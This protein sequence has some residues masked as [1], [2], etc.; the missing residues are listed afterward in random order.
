MR[1][2]R[3]VFSGNKFAYLWF[4][5]IL[6]QV[7]VHILNFVLLIRLFTLTGST[8]ATSLLWV[9]YALPA[10]IFG[11]FAA[12]TV[13]MVD[14]RKILL[15]ANFFQ[16]LTIFAY[17]LSHAT[18]VYL[19]YGVALVYSLFNQFYIPAEQAA[20]PTLVSKKNLAHANGLFFFTQ[21]ASIIVGFGFAGV[22]LQTLG[23]QTTLFLAAFLLGLA[24]VSV[25][26]LPTMKSVYKP[27][28]IEEVFMGFF[29][30]IFSGFDF[31]KSHRKIFVPFILLIAFQVG[32]AVVTVNIPALATDIFKI[33]A[34]NAGVLVVVPAG[35]GAA[36]GAVSVPRLLKRG[37][38]KKRIIEYSLVGL[39]AS[40]TAIA[41]FVFALAK[42][43]G[44]VLGVIAI[45]VTGL[46]F[47]GVLI[48]SQTFLQE[49]TPGGMR[50][51]VFGNFWFIVTVATVIPILFSGTITELFGVKTLFA[52]LGLSALVMLLL[53]KKIGHKV[54]VKSREN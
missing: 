18:T 33:N 19:L 44:L 39:V 6:S 36:M 14:K 40:L 10:L 11:P 22:L 15:I 2:F 25:N 5:Q 9:S 34:A 51:R 53:S 37:F 26:F 20:L 4:S 35:I 3:A 42:P 50:G 29:S 47:V 32:L 49:V 30:K 52:L 13:D 54:L 7:T 31:I 17:A 27:R 48:P 38:R 8:I 46:A 24:Y 23:F 16:A 28:S 1:D 21:Q 45:L 12:A 43:A 41:F